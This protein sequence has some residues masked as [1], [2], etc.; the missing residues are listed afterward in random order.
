M[1]S[2]RK[3]LVK[4]N[5]NPPSQHHREEECGSEQVCFPAQ[6]RPISKFG[7]GSFFTIA[8]TD[9]GYREAPPKQNGAGHRPTRP[10]QRTWLNGL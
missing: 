9:F 8:Q 3:I 1:I 6:R 5:H 7:M 4:S 2:V 10:G